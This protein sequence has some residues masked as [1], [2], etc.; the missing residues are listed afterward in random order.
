MYPR[1]RH[2]AI[3]YHFF[4]DFVE[5]SKLNIFKI[6]VKKKISDILTKACLKMTLTIKTIIRY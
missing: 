4:K 1:T 6:D 2:I 5:Q 3:K